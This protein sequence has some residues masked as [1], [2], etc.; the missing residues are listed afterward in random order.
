LT[1]L[2]VMFLISGVILV[3]L[4]IPMIL[5]KVAPNA[6]YGFRIPDTMNNPRI[7]YAVNAYSGKWL[8]ITGLIS[9]ATCIL[10]NFIP[11]IS[12]DTYSL[13]CMAGFFIPMT[14]G[15]IKSSIY[16][17]QLKNEKSL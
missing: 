8:L 7:W 9:I 3:A 14:I 2:L 10:A 15:F 5:G 13:I 1:E 12:V 16:V 4:S 11:N 17:K 6:I